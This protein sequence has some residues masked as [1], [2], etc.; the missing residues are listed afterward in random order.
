MQKDLL[1][2]GDL[3]AAHALF[4]SVVDRSVGQE[5]RLAVDAL[6]GIAVRCMRVRLRMYCYLVC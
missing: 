5:A 6:I 1:R 2:T 3:K 4:Q